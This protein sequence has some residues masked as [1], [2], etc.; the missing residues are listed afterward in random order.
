MKQYK[1]DKDRGIVDEADNQVLQLVGGTNKF[2]KL[3]GT[4]LVERLNI[5]AR[6]DAAAQHS[7]HPTVA[8][9]APPE[10]KSDA[11]DSG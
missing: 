10:V 6:G 9:V 5:K 7:V 4:L 3:C 8:K 2:R 11:R 1:F